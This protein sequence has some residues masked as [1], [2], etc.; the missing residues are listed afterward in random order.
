MVKVKT[1]TVYVSNTSPFSCY[2]TGQKGPKPIFYTQSLPFGG[3]D[4][5]EF[6]NGDDA[7]SFRSAVED[8]ASS[9]HEL[10]IELA[11]KHNAIFT[12]DGSA[13][14][15]SLPQVFTSS[16]SF[17]ELANQLNSLQTQ[18]KEVKQKHDL[19]GYHDQIRKLAY[20]VC[21]SFQATKDRS[22]LKLCEKLLDIAE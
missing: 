16:E 1:T 20:T 21:A 7:K 17:S 15:K 14:Q 13:S 18:P 3:L 10:F 11:E 8:L 12:I 19:N 9:N 4:F 5:Y 6:S 22:F 2:V